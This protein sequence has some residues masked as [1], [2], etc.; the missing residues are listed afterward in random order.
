V[1][2][3]K[4]KQQRDLQRERKVRKVVAGKKDDERDIACTVYNAK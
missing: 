2:K 3:V 1:E 4:G